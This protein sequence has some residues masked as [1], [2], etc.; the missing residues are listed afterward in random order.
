MSELKS[1]P[2]QVVMQS[3]VIT[4]SQYD[5]VTMAVETFKEH[6]FHHIPVLDD[7]KQ[8]VG[9]LSQT[10]INKISWGKSLFQNQRNEELNKSLYETLLIADIMTR[11]VHFLYPDQTV[12]SAIKIFESGQFHAIP[13]IEDGAVVGIVCPQDIMNMIL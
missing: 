5:T 13:I 12:E 1:K 3:N 8:I 9:I 4:L 10:D 2:I 11:N 7:D 6:R